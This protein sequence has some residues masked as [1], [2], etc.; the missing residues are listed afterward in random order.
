MWLLRITSC[1]FSFGQKKSRFF[2]EIGEKKE[3]AFAFWRKK[4]A[5]AY[6]FEYLLVLQAIHRH[7]LLAGPDLDVS[8]V[9]V[10]V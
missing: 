3:Q 9:V 6:T 8:G 1:I 7:A 2:Y 10:S 5:V 4:N